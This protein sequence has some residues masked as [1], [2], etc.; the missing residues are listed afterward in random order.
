MSV[1]I[2]A[3]IRLRNNLGPKSHQR[4]HEVAGQ[5]KTGEASGKGKEHFQALS[6][7]LLERIKFLCQAWH[8]L[9]RNVSAKLHTRL[10]EQRAAPISI[11][12][13]GPEVDFIAPVVNGSAQFGVAQP[14]DLSLARA[15]GKPV[16]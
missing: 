8:S 6:G 16:R 2:Q 13:G 15:A 9:Y 1:Y 5:E 12:E 7:K 3:S 14:A 4:N 10:C 11:V